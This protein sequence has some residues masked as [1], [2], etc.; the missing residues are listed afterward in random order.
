MRPDIYLFNPTCE[1]AV[2]NGSEHFMAPAQLRKFENELSALPGIIARPKDIVL[3]DRLPGL[4]FSDQLESAGFHLP[5]FRI[6]KDLI[7]DSSFLSS[8]KGFLFPWG[9]S[10]AT[11]KKL[12]PLKSGCCFEFLSSP[13]AEWCE[14]HRDLYSRKSS[15]AIL[16]S[17]LE[18]NNSNNI[19]SF[20]DLPEICINHEQIILLQKK[21]G[22]V[23]VKAP[24]SASGRGLQI[25]RNEEY[26]QTNRQVI[27]GILKQQAYVVTGPWHNK[28]LDLSC[29]FF[30]DGNGNIEY[31]GLT[32]FSTDSSGRYTGNYLQEL[33]TDLQP[34]LL[35]FFKETIP[36][37]ITCI[38]NILKTSNYATDYYGWF[39][40]D[41][42]ICKTSEGKLLLHPCLEINCRY[43][44]GAITLSLRDHLA[45]QSIG[46]F[47]IMHY[48]SG[49]LMQFYNDRM[50]KKP[51]IVENGK[52]VS[53]FLPLTPILPDYNFGAWM[54][55]KVKN[56]K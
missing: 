9:W 34:D 24:W 52:I 11:H 27:S 20:S 10:P 16:R 40:V 54:E 49:V 37:T 1:L 25:L 17:F 44:M 38:Q 42:L 32:T 19:L 33:P 35:D 45:G 28:L 6:T 51:L 22:K 12:L 36:G 41:M 53:G 26:N 7:S 14:N 13:V 43:T 55:V 15:L 39:G 46:E 18:N 21:W 56:E 47:R 4:Q 8:E 30:S 29:Q 23:V 48:K 31:K 2:A 50:R 5:S 3:V